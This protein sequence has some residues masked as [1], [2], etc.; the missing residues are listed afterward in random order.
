MIKIEEYE[1]AVAEAH[2]EI[3]E[4]KKTAKDLIDVNTVELLTD[5]ADIASR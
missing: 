2:N 3:E 4:Y 5:E 1:I